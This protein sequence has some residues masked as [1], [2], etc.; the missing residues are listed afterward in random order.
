[1][2]ALMVNSFFG[3][4]YTKKY[5]EGNHTFRYSQIFVSPTPGRTRRYARSIP[6][7]GG[8]DDSGVDTATED[9]GVLPDRRHH[10]EVLVG[11]I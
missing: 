5:G 8:R 11:A 9:P 3:L 1:M 10:G 7:G 6:G 2:L 4:F